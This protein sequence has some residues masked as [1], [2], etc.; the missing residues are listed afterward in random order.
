MK[1][2]L[3]ALNLPGC[4]PADSGPTTYIPDLKNNCEPPPA[5]TVFMSSCGAWIVTPA[6]VDS[7]T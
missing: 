5:A 4:A 6:V 3:Y 7:I 2:Y 1:D